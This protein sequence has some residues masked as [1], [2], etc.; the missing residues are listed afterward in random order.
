MTTLTAVN[1]RITGDSTGL[2]TALDRAGTRLQKF[3]QQTRQVINDVAKW[4][5][6]VVAAGAAVGVALVRRSLEAIDA[7]AK[8]ARQLRSTS[9]GL[10][11][12]QRAGELAGVSSGQM[13]MALRRLDVALGEAAQGS[14]RSA[15]AMKKLGLSAAEVAG[16][17]ADQRLAAINEALRE[18]VPAAERAAVAAS[19]FG[20]RYGSLVQEIDKG[21]IANAAREVDALG[22]A[23]SE[24]DAATIERAN[25]AMSSIGAVVSGVANRIAVQLAPL[26]EA[27]ATK[28]R[29]SAIEAN[30][31]GSIIGSV[32]SGVLRSVGFVADAIH[33]LRAVL[34]GVEIGFRA[35]GAS[36]LFVV[37]QIARGWIELAN[38]IPGINVNPESNFLVQTARVAREELSA[39]RDEL[40]ALS[41]QQMPSEQFKAW[42]DAVTVAANQASEATVAARANMQGLAGPELD[43]NGNPV[44]TEEE[45]EAHREQIAER[46]ERVRQGL[47]TEAEI[48]REAYAAKQEAIAEAFANEMGIS[49]EHKEQLARLEEQHNAKLASIRQRGMSALEQVTQQ[50]YRKQAAFVAKGIAD[51]TQN[52]ATGNKA[53]FEL[54]KVAAI[55]GALLDMKEAI[56]GAY[57]VGSKIGGP[58]LGAAY[59][60]AAGAA[61]LANLNGIRSQSFGGGGGVAPSASQTPAPAVTN[62]SAAPAQQE[63]APASS[64]RTLTI[65]GANS[66]IQQLAE[67]LV[68]FQRDGGRVVFTQ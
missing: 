64:G 39:A 60:A 49:E 40:V 41:G 32:M 57:K 28:F 5:A 17:D 53:M 23:V 8:L 26:I 46:L 16:M 54:N 22:N 44:M 24:V 25:D 66:F 9:Q 45:A 67:E 20:A 7:Q 2:Q 21:A 6:A 62:V 36:V 58:P 10:A 31:F 59:A 55:S 37:E 27:I 56:T 30:G 43:E 29:E 12:V 14:G 34:K 63:A 19:L 47:L 33:G 35:F 65:R 42:A 1:A 52:V 50:S 38:L 4:G 48:E 61:Q 51:M 68:D 3:G 13:T 15:D 11:N 18:N